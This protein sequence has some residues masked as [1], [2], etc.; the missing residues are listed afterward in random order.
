M[1]EIT[2]NDLSIEDI[3]QVARNDIES[4]RR[5]FWLERVS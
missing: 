4:Y 1:I 5:I 2:G 3:V